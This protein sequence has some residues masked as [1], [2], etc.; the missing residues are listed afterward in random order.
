MPKKK[1]K[2][3]P[4][5]PGAIDLT[6]VEGAKVD[7]VDMLIKYA[8]KPIKMEKTDGTLAEFPPKEYDWRKE[9]CERLAKGENLKVALE[10]MMVPATTFFKELEI[11]P[12]FKKSHDEAMG[13][14]AK[15]AQYGLYYL[16]IN[17][18]ATDR[19]ALAPDLVNKYGS[20]SAKSEG[21]QEGGAEFV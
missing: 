4:L 9:I 6:K 5:K 2:K 13:I 3:L 19:K 16:A 21:K 14:L 1:A 12:E 7:D 20:P 15:L 8:V 10:E 18:S 11:N 17:G